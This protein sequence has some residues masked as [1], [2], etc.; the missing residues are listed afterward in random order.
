LS[1]DDPFYK[2][3]FSLVVA[4]HF[5]TYLNLEAWFKLFKTSINF[6]LHVILN[7]KY[8]TP[9]YSY[10]IALS[11]ANNTQDQPIKKET[12]CYKIYSCKIIL[13]KLHPKLKYV[14]LASLMVY[15][16]PMAVLLRINT[17]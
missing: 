2:E 1:I 5:K 4:V 3:F 15:L 9:K 6:I 12:L 7:I 11:E 8:K 17:L 13:I 10:S 16:K 14:Y